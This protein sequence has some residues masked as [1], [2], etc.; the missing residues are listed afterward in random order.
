[1][2]KMNAL[3]VKME[4]VTL[5]GKGRQNVTCF[6]YQ[7]Y[8]IDSKIYFLIIL[9]LG[10]GDGWMDASLIWINT[11]PLVDMFYLGVGG[12]CFSLKLS[13]IRVTTVYMVKSKSL[14]LYHYL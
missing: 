8:E 5:I 1:M 3:T 13:C 6:G 12:G 11:F 4:T 10:G 2:R 9:F 7:V 14:F